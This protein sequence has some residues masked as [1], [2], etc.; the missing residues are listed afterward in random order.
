PIA[1]IN[2][3][4]DTLERIYKTQPEKVETYL[5]R[6]RISSKR[7]I[8]QVDRALAIAGADSI[9]SET[10]LVLLDEL[11]AELTEEIRETYPKTSFSII[12]SN[13]SIQL[14][15]NEVRSVLYSVIE[16]AA[17]YSS[18]FCDEP[19]VVISISES[20][21]GPLVKIKDNGPGLGE[22]GDYLFKAFSRGKWATENAVEG[23]GLGLHLAHKVAQKWGWTIAV[24]DNIDESGLSV[25]LRLVSV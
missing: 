24:S 11:V 12:K 5:K 16:N 23:T 14:P 13:I 7:L 17:K 19:S 4:L 8:S 9:V 21:S 1:S 22:A 6:A 25:S 15:K 18:H 20:N 2:L 10:S 3:C